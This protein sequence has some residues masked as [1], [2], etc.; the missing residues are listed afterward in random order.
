MFST[1][2]LRPARGGGVKIQYAR[3]NWVGMPSWRCRPFTR[4]AAFS[5]R[6]IAIVGRPYSRIFT[7][8]K[9]IC[10]QL[11]PYDPRGL[12]AGFSGLERLA[13]ELRAQKFERGFNCYK[14][15]LM[16]RG[17]L[18]ALEF[19]T[20]RYARRRPQLSSD[21]GRTAPRHGKSLRNGEVLLSGILRRAGCWIRA[22]RNIY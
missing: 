22:G 9:E 5:W 12:N 10:D 3:P 14:M 4:C 13:A 2:R 6:G 17:W 16:R 1:R 15:R 18:G 8:I 7:A 21:E 20:N 19:G 11:I